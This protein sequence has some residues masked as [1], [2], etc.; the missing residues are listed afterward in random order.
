MTRSVSEKCEH[1]PS[2]PAPPAK[3]APNSQV[4]PGEARLLGAREVLL[5]RAPRRRGF[6]TVHA[7]FM[8]RTV[9]LCVRDTWAFTRGEPFDPPSILSPSKDERSLRN[10]LVESR[11]KPQMAFV[12]SPLPC[13]A[14]IVVLLVFAA[15][16]SAGAQTATA[17]VVAG[18]VQDQTGAVLHG[19]TVELVG[20]GGVLA[21]STTADPSDAFRF[22]KVAAGQ[23]E[24]RARYEGFKSQ[25]HERHH[26]VR[27]Q[28]L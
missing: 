7:R 16:S 20:A 1:T 10:R 9:V 11:A 17:G 22:E 15:A 19:A 24:L 2:R 3:N 13:R 5:R 14:A 21:Q 18:V 4:V 12:L 28:R 27:G 26:I 6:V 23:Y 25:R 8:N